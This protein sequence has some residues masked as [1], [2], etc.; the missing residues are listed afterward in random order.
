MKSNDWLNTKEAALKL[1]VTLRTLY[2]LIDEGAIPA[3]KFGRV[4]RLKTA[5]FEA[6]VETCRIEPGTLA[7]LYPE[8]KPASEG[9]RR[10]S[11]R[12]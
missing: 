10:K 12:A 9:R 7:H 2:R 3:Y 6:F 11:D 8:A 1:G 5:D 4:I